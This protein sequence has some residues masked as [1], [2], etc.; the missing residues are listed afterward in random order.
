MICFENLNLRGTAKKDIL[1]YIS[2]THPQY[3]KAYQNIYLKGDM[4]YWQ[5]LEDEIH[6]LSEKSAV[7]LVSY[8]YH[9]KIKKGGK[10]HD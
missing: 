7:P 2:E 5:S 9:S 10:N 3:L 4:S 8:F 6:K 1:E